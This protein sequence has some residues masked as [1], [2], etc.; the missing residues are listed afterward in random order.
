MIEI[1][2]FEEFLSSIYHEQL[3]RCPIHLAIGQEASSAGTILACEKNDALF[4]HHRSH[5]HYLAKG[6]D[7]FILLDELLGLSSGCAK[8][9]GGSQHSCSLKNN[10]IGATAIVGGTLPV[11]AGY[12]WGQKID[13]ENGITIACLGDGGMEE[14]IFWETLNYISFYQLPII[15]LIE[16]NNYACYTA[17]NERRHNFDLQKII[18]GLNLNYTYIPKGF[19]VQS[20]YQQVAT[21][22]KNHSIPHIIKIDVQRRYEHCG[23]HIDD[24]LS[25]RDTEIYKTDRWDPIAYSL[26]Q[27]TNKQRKEI[28]LY[29]EQYKNKLNEHYTLS[30][31][32][33]L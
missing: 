18:S 20:I 32:K 10:F 5:A 26:K 13:Q 1:R 9:D 23:P 29:R 11:A 8:G 17:V 31:N 14:G 6:G 25:Y 28:D 22:R 12:A 7:P 27:L 33:I 4:S 15:V 30:K 24:H 19:D 3:I 2:S 16:D 21:I